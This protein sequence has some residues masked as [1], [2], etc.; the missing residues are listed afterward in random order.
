MA[1]Q[2]K[3]TY[4]SDLSEYLSNAQHFALI[5]FDKTSHLTLEKLRKELK[6][7][8]ASFKVVKNSL[9]EKAVEKLVKSKEG[10]EDLKTLFPLKDSSAILSLGENYSAALSK[11]FAFAKKEGSLGFKFGILDATLYQGPDLEKIAQLPN[12]DILLAKVIGGMK[13]PSSKLVF[14]LKFNVTK[15]VHILA[16]RSK[17]SN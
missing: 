9:F 1:N 2:T 10:L 12:R 3:K 14:S 5:K 16:E 4:V 11:F 8:G 17:Q 6:K 13:S 15:L 7:D